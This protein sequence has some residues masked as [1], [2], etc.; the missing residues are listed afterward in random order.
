MAVEKA[1]EK[2][3]VHQEV[4]MDFVNV[5]DATSKRR[6]RDKN[7]FNFF[8]CFFK[9]RFN[10]GIFSRSLDLRRRKL[11]KYTTTFSHFWKHANQVLA[12]FRFRRGKSVM[13][14]A[15]RAKKQP[16][17]TQLTAIQQIFCCFLKIK[18]NLWSHALEI[19]SVR[20][21]RPLALLFELVIPRLQ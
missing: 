21:A 11:R 10:P 13:A 19:A 15:M 14:C 7:A 12:P 5:E 16:G 4:R 6:E 18:K 20:D 1:D 3:C 17:T 9:L 2:R 8:V